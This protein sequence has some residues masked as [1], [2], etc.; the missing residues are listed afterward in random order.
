VR[1]D[2][3]DLREQQDALRRGLED[4]SPLGGLLGGGLHAALI[5]LEELVSPQRGEIRGDSKPQ[6]ELFSQVVAEGLG[7]SFD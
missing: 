3:G 4:S 7:R 6:A 1:A 5:G 2:R